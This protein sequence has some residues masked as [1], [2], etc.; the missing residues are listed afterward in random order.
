MDI[1]GNRIRTLR[2]KKGIAQEDLANG[3]NVSRQ[4]ISRWEANIRQPSVEKLNEICKIL[5]VSVEDI[6]YDL[7]KETI[8]SNENELALCDV[9]NEEKDFTS[10]TK[11]V[12]S[13][14]QKQ[15]TLKA[16]VFI[17]SI[18]IILLVGVIGV[19]IG[20]ALACP[21]EDGTQTVYTVAHNL[22]S[23]SFAH[24]V[25]FV[26]LPVIVA[27]VVKIIILVTKNNYYRGKN[28]KD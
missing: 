3:I 26:L 20:Y 5:D 18:I 9:V 21:S 2:K 22:S 19:V 27:L 28:G 1:I 11:S 16:K 24:I 14:K 6:V 13:K 17:I 10:Q 4:T 15:I 12:Q 8:N 25:I 23:T 7:N